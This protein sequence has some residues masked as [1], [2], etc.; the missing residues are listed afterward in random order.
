MDSSTRLTKYVSATTIVTSDVANMWYGGLY[1]TAE[2]ALYDSNHPLVAGHVHDGV[3]ADGHAQKIHLVD[4]VTGQITNPNVG[5]NAITPRNINY[6]TLEE[7][8]IPYITTDGEYK[9]NLSMITPSMGFGAFVEDTTD[10]LIMHTTEDYS[11]TGTDF[12]FGS[13]SLDDIGSGDAGIED[14][15]NR[16]LF[17]RDKAAFR[18]GV[19]AGEAALPSGVIVS[20]LWDEANRGLYS[21]TIGVNSNASGMASAVFGNFNETISDYSGILSGSEGEVAADSDFSVIAGGQKGSIVKSPHSSILGGDSNDISESSHSSILGGFSNNISESVYSSVGSGQ[22]SSIEN[23]SFSFILSGVTNSI[24]ESPYSSILGGLSNDISD[25]SHSSLV[26]GTGSLITNSVKSSIL[27]GESNELKDSEC[28]SILGGKANKLDNSYYAT[29]LGNGNVMDNANNSFVGGA[30]VGINTG[31]S[32]FVWGNDA[33]VHSNIVSGSEL[34]IVG[35]GSVDES[36]Q[37]GVN[38]HSPDV[39]GGMGAHIVGSTDSGSSPLRLENLESSNSVDP[40]CVDA[41]GNVFISNNKLAPSTSVDRTQVITFERYRPHSD[42]TL[43]SVQ[44]W[45]FNSAFMSPIYGYAYADYVKPWGDLSSSYPSCPVLVFPYQGFDDNEGP[46]ATVRFSLYK[47][48]SIKNI[49]LHTDLDFKP[50]TVNPYV[51]TSIGWRLKISKINYRGGEHT[52]LAGGEGNS[53]VMSAAPTFNSNPGWDGTGD[54][55]LGLVEFNTSHFGAISGEDYHIYVM[56]ISPQLVDTNPAYDSRV[57]FI[58]VITETSTDFEDFVSSPRV[59][60]R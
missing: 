46:L 6:Y 34:F 52:Y 23:S 42:V 2:S 41:D 12:V 36:Y 8:A 5:D 22:G 4:H 43:N 31:E 20:K 58:E 56:Q 9:L 53:Y 47:G 38:T 16:F 29:I 13:S 14:G 24:S 51:R 48:E 25:S 44:D 19:I 18:A 60:S 27:G 28:A 17:D 15:D 45:R 40:L 33:S 37:M 39:L 30:G 21:V 55:T 54:N 57:W 3:H 1:G 10:N 32:T 26:G 35:T 7:N 49:V 11:V 59:S 50:P